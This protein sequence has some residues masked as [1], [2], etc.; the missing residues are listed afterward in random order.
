MKKGFTLLELIIV[1]II[2]GVLATLGFTQY[3]K[4]VE[5]GRT[6]EAKAILGDIRTAENAYYLEYATYTTLP[7]L[8]VGAPAVAPACT[9]TTHYFGYNIVAAAGTFTATATRCTSGGKTPNFT[10]AAYAVTLDQGGNW[11]GTAGYF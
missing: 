3:V 2:L 5:K 9:A 11:S 7:N 4:V 10:G 1:V 8:P 6:A